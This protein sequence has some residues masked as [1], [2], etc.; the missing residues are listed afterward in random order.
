MESYTPGD[1]RMPTVNT[2]YG[3][4]G[5]VICFDADFPDLMRQGGRGGVDVMLVPSSDW[6]GFGR[7]HTQKAILRAVENGYAVVRQDALGYA[8]VVDHQGRS[9]ATADFFTADQQTMIANVPV[10][11]SRTMYATVGDLF[12]WLC[13]A[14][15]VLLVVIAVT[16]NRA[17]R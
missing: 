12:A 1:G 16:R 3:R 11:G 2:E 8:Q 17:A 5:N 9:L 15:L 10:Q 6:P 14:G 4:L 13:L 7:V